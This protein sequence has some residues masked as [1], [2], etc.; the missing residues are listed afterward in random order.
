MRTFLQGRRQGKR[1]ARVQTVARRRSALRGTWP[2]R[3]HTQTIGTSHHPPRAVAA[4]A[5][6]SVRGSAWS[7]R[8]PA[9]MARMN[10]LS[11][12]RIR[13]RQQAQRQR[14]GDS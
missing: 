13:E 2:T 12:H 7:M 10:I 5:R 1:A 11:R 3:R 6:D 8:P 14:R 9:H 4:Q